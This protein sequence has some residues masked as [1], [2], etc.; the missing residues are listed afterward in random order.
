VNFASIKGAHLPVY[1]VHYILKLSFLWLRKNS[2]VKYL[3]SLS[4]VSLLLVS[5]SG[6]KFG[7]SDELK[8][9]QIQIIASHNSYHLRTDPAV[10][11]FLKNLYGLHLLPKDL[12]P[13]EID[14]SNASLTDQFEKYG[15]RGIELDVNYDPTGG[16]FADRRGLAWVWKRSRSK[17]PD[18][19]QPGFKLIHITDFDF[20]STNATFKGALKEI[21]SWSDAHPDHLPIFINVEPKTDATGDVVHQLHKLAKS[22]PF[23]SIAADAMDLEV[24]SVFGNDLKG[25]ITPDQVRGSYIS[26]EQ[27]VLAGH[28]PALHEARGKVVFIIDDG[29]KVRALYRK[30]H[31]SYTG[32]AMFVYSEPGTPEAAFVICNDPKKDFDRIQQCVKQGYIVRTRCDEG[33]LEARSG[34]YSTMQ[35]AMASWAQIISTDYYRPDARAGK[36]GWTNYQVKFP[37]GDLARIDSISAA[38]KDKI[39]VIKE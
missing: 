10:L 14:Y 16:R 28:W 26:L 6:D 12:N 32:R 15:V 1:D 8:L 29:N 36:K 23:D 9:N 38:G 39:G 31:P 11:R 5:F 4:F 7:V 34:D 20:N 27:A 13:K 25:V 21:K 3:I 24:K 30:G 37:N 2:I 18:M 17:D 33:T 35:K 19:M 22:A